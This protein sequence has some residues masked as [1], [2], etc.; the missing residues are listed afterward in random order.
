MS[1]AII[2]ALLLFIAWQ[3]WSATRERRLLLN[4]IIGRTASEVRVLDNDP[5]PRHDPTTIDP[6]LREFWEHGEPIGL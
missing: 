6:E 4:R 2:V 3:Q 5:T 1:F